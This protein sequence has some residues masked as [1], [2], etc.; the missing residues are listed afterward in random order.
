MQIWCLDVHKY[1]SVILTITFIYLCEYICAFSYNVSIWYIYLNLHL[2]LH[3]CVHMCVHVYVYL[4]VFVLPKRV[5]TYV[6]YLFVYV[7]VYLHV[8]VHVDIYLSI[9]SSS[10]QIP[11]LLIVITGDDCFLTGLTKSIENTYP[12]H[13]SRANSLMR[14]VPGGPLPSIQ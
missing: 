5:W 14:I 12:H 8:H 3:V 11:E 1:V 4:Y 10:M 7:Y 2:C 13:Q 6:W 9:T